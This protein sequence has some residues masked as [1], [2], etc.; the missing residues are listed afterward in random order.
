MVLS[1]PPGG[2]P[3]AESWPGANEAKAEK[4]GV[5][6]LKR[7]AAAHGFQLRHSAYGYA[8]INSAHKQ[9]DDRNDMTLAE[10]A[11]WLGRV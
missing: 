10:V 1:R 3:R 9:V 8:L 11:S 5:R 6:S 7:Q 4:L 2:A